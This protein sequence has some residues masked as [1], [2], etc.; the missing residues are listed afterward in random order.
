LMY[1]QMHAAEQSCPP[2]RTRSMETSTNADGKMQEQI[3]G[4]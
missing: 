2:S 1:T 3:T 4:E